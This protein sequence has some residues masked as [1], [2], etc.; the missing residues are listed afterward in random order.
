M[1]GLNLVL[2][3]SNSTYNFKVRIRHKAGHRLW[4]EG[5]VTNMLFNKSIGAVVISFRDITER[6]KVEEKLALSALIVNSSDD[7]I[8]GMTMDKTINSWNPGAEKVFGYTSKEVIGKPIQLIIPPNLHEEERIISENLGLGKPVSHFETCRIKKD[9][10]IIDVSITVSP[11]TDE[12][13]EAIGFSKIIRDI[14]LRKNLEEERD[15]MIADLV[16]RN[17]DLEQFSYIISHNLRT[18]VANILGIS[19]LMQS[20]E[21]LPSEEEELLLGLNKSVSGLD[22]IIKDLNDILQT[23]KEINEA[24]VLVNLT[25]IIFTIQSNIS[26][27][28][29][30]ENVNFSVDFSPKNE[31]LTIKSYLYSIFYNLISNSI[32][33][34]HPERDP[35]IEIKSRLKDKGIEIR[36]KDN[37]LGIDLEKQGNQVFGLYK[38]F[39]FH[40]EGKGMGLFMVKT[41]IEALGGKVSIKSEVNHGTEFIIEFE[42]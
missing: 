3:K 32:K 20:S 7:A 19:N 30:K 21:L 31:F 14:T 39:H 36:Y 17:R 35:V 28:I 29:L 10:K 42:Q 27:L 6:I 2:K 11:I 25:D 12:S 37:G 16:Q 22:D 26:H 1:E 23:K 34:K 24:K 38:R 9:G 40:R 41:Q 13:G 5:T 4:I 33:Y 15:K 8:I 18:P